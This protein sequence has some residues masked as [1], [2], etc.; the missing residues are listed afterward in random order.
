MNQNKWVAVTN[1][2]KNYRRAF[3]QIQQLLSQVYLGFQPHSNTHD[4]IEDGS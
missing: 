3:F 1:W 4:S 2:S